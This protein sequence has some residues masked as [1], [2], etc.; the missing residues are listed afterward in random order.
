MPSTSVVLFGVATPG[1]QGDV[2]RL[3]ADS[4]LLVKIVLLLL[5]GFSVLSWAVIIERYRSFKRA[6]ADTIRFLRDLGAEKRLAD[7]RARTDRYDSSPLV[8]IFHAG[9]KELA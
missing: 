9:F 2:L 6:E 1:F 3:I 5:V 7:L 4:G 8:P